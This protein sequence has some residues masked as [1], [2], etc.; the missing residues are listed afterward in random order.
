MSMK[1]VNYMHILLG[2]PLLFHYG[3]IMD[4]IDDKYLGMVKLLFLIIPFIVRFPNLKNMRRSDWINAMHWFLFL[5][6]GLFITSKKRLPIGV[7][8][9]V[10]YAGIATIAIHM[11]IIYQ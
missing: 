10:K 9:L 7:Y 6:V 11:Y 8:D 5:P 1:Q 2:G 4:S 3:D